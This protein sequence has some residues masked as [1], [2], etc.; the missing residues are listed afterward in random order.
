MSMT[1][2]ELYQFLVDYVDRSLPEEEAESF[3]KHIEECPPCVAYM[4]SYETTIR[5]GKMVCEK[6]DDAAEAPE[7]LIKA[8]LEAKKRL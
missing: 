4:H 2:R 8:I 7:E 1:C 6:D 3:R 5:A